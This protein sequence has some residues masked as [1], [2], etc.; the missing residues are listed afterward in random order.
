MKC[1]A[2]IFGAVYSL[3]APLAEDIVTAPASQAYVERIF[4]VC[5]LL[6]AGRRNRMKKSLGMRVFL[7]L[8]AHVIDW[9]KDV[10]HLCFQFSIVI[11][12][13]FGGLNDCYTVLY[14]NTVARRDGLA[15]GR[16]RLLLNACLGMLITCKCF[17]FIWWGDVLNCFFISVFYLLHVQ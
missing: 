11:E 16:F 10:P 4:S 2:N 3:L 6:T 1:A 13:L 14:R 17:K 12:V 7:K 8:N 15:I 9:M 5:G